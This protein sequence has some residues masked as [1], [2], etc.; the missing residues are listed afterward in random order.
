MAEPQS[1]LDFVEGF[2]LAH[3]IV[4]LKDMGIL[5]VMTEPIAVEVL[6]ERF[7]VDELMLLRVLQYLS[8]RT[9]LI[10]CQGEQYRTT[11]N[12][13]THTRFLVDQY[14]GAY[15]PNAR[16]LVDILRCPQS[17]GDIVDRCKHAL[18]F[19]ALKGPSVAILSTIIQQ[20][21]LNYI[22]DLGCG[23]A[24]LL[25]DLATNNQRFVGW[26][27]DSSAEMCAEANAHAAKLGVSQRIAIYQGDATH[28]EDYVPSD[29][30]RQIRTIVASSL[31]N[32]FFATDSRAC[33]AFLRRLHEA[34][35]GQTLIVSD[36]YGCLGA[37]AKPWSRKTALHDFVQVISGQGVPPNNLGAW[38]AIYEEAGC[39]LVYSLEAQDDSG[40][41]HIVRLDGV[42]ITV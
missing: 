13:N 39:G 21:E 12:Y 2:H 8:D 24:A 6:A 1:T 9:D 16:Q 26:G 29:V 23:P 41:I 3:S 40:F 15:G 27:I 11:D 18:A 25:F 32:E 14:I 33:I 20:L 4:A 19:S 34:F 35:P 30:R 31:L 38:Q 7:G 37:S 42:K 28:F 22:L 36:Y 17:A 10:E 5:E